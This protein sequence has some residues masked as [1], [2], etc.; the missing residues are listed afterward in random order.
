MSDGQ[1]V[2]WKGPH[3][4]SLHSEHEHK[5]AGKSQGTRE[6]QEEWLCH[7][8]EVAILSDLYGGV[9]V[10]SGLLLSFLDLFLS[11]LLESALV[12]FWYVF[13]YSGHHRRYHPPT[14]GTLVICVHCCMYSM[15]F[16]YM[17]LFIFPLAR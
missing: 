9:L 3:F 17:V 14:G 12:C 13:Y 11:I 10:L 2:R 5:R 1:L 6:N 15:A 16:C 8:G 4:Y 7:T